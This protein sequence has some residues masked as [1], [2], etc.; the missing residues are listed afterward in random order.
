MYTVKE[1]PFFPQYFYCS[2]LLRGGRQML[3]KD[4]IFL[5]V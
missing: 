3:Q 5:R 4:L 2:H 1:V